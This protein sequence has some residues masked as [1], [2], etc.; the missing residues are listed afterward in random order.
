MSTNF[1]SL[2]GPE[3]GTGPLA[4]ALSVLARDLATRA[5]GLWRAYWD[6]QSRRPTVLMLAALDDRVLKDLGLT[7]SEIWPAVHGRDPAAVRPYDP[8]WRQR[9]GAQV[10]R[11]S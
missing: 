7:R 2:V 3:R 6:Y 10:R 8:R 9:P 5:R 1:N 11:R 4:R